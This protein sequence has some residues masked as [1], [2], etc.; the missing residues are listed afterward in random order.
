MS[1]DLDIASE[2]RNSRVNGIGV[3]TTE[4]ALPFM[5]RIKDKQ[6]MIIAKDGQHRGPGAD[7]YK[8]KSNDSDDADSADMDIPSELASESADHTESKILE[9]SETEEQDK[10][11]SRLRSVHVKLM[12]SDELKRDN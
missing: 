10:S 9:A 4:P 7:R 3:K 6:A 5:K 12:T 8:R 2:S 11:D 1:S